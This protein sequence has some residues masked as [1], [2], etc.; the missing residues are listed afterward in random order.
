MATNEEILLNNYSDDS[1]TKQYISNVLAPRVFHDIPLNVLNTGHFSLI[2]E[3]ISQITEQLG[4]TA[5]FYHNESFITKSVLADSIYAEAAIFNIGYSY[6]TPSHCT[7]LLELKIDDIYKNAKY[8]PDTRLNEFILDKDTKFNLDNG[9]VYSLDYDILIRYEDIESSNS[10]S[11]AHAWNIQYTNT[12][13]A[14]VCAINKDPYIKYRV[15]DV[16]LCM[17]VEASEYQREVHT[18]VNNMTNGVPN[19]DT[20]ITCN[21]HIAGFDIKYIDN[22]GNVSYLERDHI[23]AMH[24]TINDSDPYVHYIMDSPQTIRFMWQLQGTR[25]FVPETN[26]HYE[27]IIYICHGDAANFTAFKDTSQPKIIT[28]ANKYNNNSNVMKTAFVI[29]ASLGGTNIG[30][31]ETTRRETIEAY[32]TANVISTDHDIDEWF[33]TFYFKNVLYPFFFKRRDDP[34]GRIWSGY[35]ALKD[36]DNY[37]FRTNTLHGKIPYEILYNNN[38]NTVSSNEI[39]IPPGWIWEYIDSDNK[40][41]LFT[42][43]PYVRNGKVIETAKTLSNISKKFIFSNPFGIRIQ[44]D[45]F[46]IGYFNPWINGYYSCTKVNTVES[47][48]DNDSSRIY[49]ASPLIT[50]IK[51]TYKDDYYLISTYILP[52]VDAMINGQ[53]LV[54][55]LRNNVT[56]P[57]FTGAMWNYFKT[58]LDM[59]SSDIP[60]VPLTS[61][62]CYLSFDPT[63]TYF[64]VKE[65]NRITDGTWKLSTV[66]IEDNSSLDNKIVQIPISGSI[67][68]L[69][70]NDDIWGDD[71]RC[72]DYSVYASENVDINIYPSLSTDSLI[73]F[74]RIKTQNY[75][76][77][78]I[79]EDAV[80]GVINRIVVGEAITTDLTKYGE[81]NLVKIGKSYSENIYLNIYFNNEDDEGNI[82]ENRITYTIKNSANVYMPYSYE[83]DEDGNYVF[84]LNNL[85]P[86]AI[87]LYADMKPSPETGSVNYYRIPFSE[88]T[89]TT[90]ISSTE[91]STHTD[92]MF[93]ISNSLLP[94]N[95]N[96][97]RVVL[98]TLV[99]G[100]VT[101]YIEMQPVNLDKDGSFLF[102]AK[103]YPL[104]ELIDIDDM[105]SIASTNNGGGSW[106]SPNNSS[107]NIDVKDPQMKILILF[108]SDDPTRDSEIQIGDDFTGYRIVD[109]YFIDGLDLVQ[110]LK[111]MRSVVTFNESS[112]P[113]TEQYDLYKSMYK[114]SEYNSYDERN[115]YTIIKYAYKKMNELESS[116]TETD[117][118]ITY[119]EYQSIC[120]YEITKLTSYGNKYN[121]VM[122]IS[123]TT[124]P[125]WIQTIIDTL[126]IICDDTSSGYDVNWEDTYTS[127]NSYVDLLSDAFDIANINGGVTIQ[128][129]PFVEYSLMLS[130]RFESFVSSFTQVHKAIEPVIFKRLE[131]NNYLDCKLIA[132]YGLPHSYSSD[133]DFEREDVFWPDLN[134]QIEFDVKLYNQSLATN[135]ITDLK[136]EIKTYFNRLTSIHTAVD[137]V[138]M[139]NN[140]YISHILKLMADASQN[141]AYI[142]FKGWYTNE[143]GKSNGNYMNADY[144]AIV[145]KW[146]KLE[147]MPTDELERFVPEMFVLDDDN[148]V[149]NIIK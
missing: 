10:T 14:N 136:N 124:T 23:L 4:F 116:Y 114:E 140:I 75:Y 52:T 48:A 38:N 123:S 106:K 147:D 59:F 31:I 134:I 112:L 53:S 79:N 21:D 12:D 58:P 100:S 43:T 44:K 17:I 97:M 143:K 54:K 113:T 34:W 110:E 19:Q 139:N 99:N 84:D 33:K 22:N 118:D 70:G 51:R 109:E 149:I 46:A 6:A 68:Y 89:T 85:G 146:K 108:K 111:E 72:K 101:G 81:T 83:I 50:N 129:M 11:V 86:N 36:T 93:Y 66:W 121:T 2:N 130:D 88:L 74:E 26:S 131:G 55:Y 133:M 69:Y 103:M 137:L 80:V 87:I 76:E 128:Q 30:T 9:S 67:N 122:N 91:S 127:L 47:V 62:D 3:Y 27:I 102:D 71:G 96:N 132:T 42:V 94:M 20:V 119:E 45:P 98:Q 49:H 142:K 8:N 29:G 1:N 145:Q 120:E 25:Y 13:E 60:L 95:Q 148:I 32:N 28:S 65:K 138:S 90:H 7:F 78:R 105:I 41:R 35:L 115:M 40:E 39:I 63:K 92:A 104:N 16:W 56:E 24:D 135:T 61:D 77:L 107:V 15:T 5:S 82:V 18:V 144:Q 125:E 117:Y 37:V 126:N 57:T 141:V 64:C 73:Q